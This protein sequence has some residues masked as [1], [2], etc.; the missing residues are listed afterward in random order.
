M[1]KLN[2][3]EEAREFSNTPPAFIF[4]SSGKVNNVFQK[5]NLNTTMRYN[6]ENQPVNTGQARHESASA[7][8]MPAECEVWRL[9]GNQA[10][11]NGDMRKAEECYTHGINSSSSSR[12]Q[13]IAQTAL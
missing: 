9:R 8:V 1:K 5:K 6:Q 11:K 7:S 4:G 3:S 12:R 2:I 13:V 10:Y